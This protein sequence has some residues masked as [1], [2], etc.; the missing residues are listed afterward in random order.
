MMRGEP[1]PKACDWRQSTIGDHAESGRYQRIWC[2]DCR[3][4]LVIAAQ[5]L[6]EKFLIPPPTPYW[7]PAQH[8]VCGKCGSKK[9]GMM[10]ASYDPAR[11]QPE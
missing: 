7:T 1:P 5:D 3:H 4:E 9:A 6:I 10:L 8:L 11:D 2:E